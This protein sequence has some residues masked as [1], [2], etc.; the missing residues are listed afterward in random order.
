MKLVNDS[1][2]LFLGSRYNFIVGAT[3]IGVQ[4]AAENLKDDLI[5]LLQYLLIIQLYHLRLT[6]NLKYFGWI[7][8]ERMF[9]LHILITAGS[10]N[11][12]DQSAT[13]SQSYFKLSKTAE[14]PTLTLTL[15]TWSLIDTILQ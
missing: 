10:Q 2:Y 15:L 9:L 8:R 14:L 7:V 6:K 1:V 5:Y 4:T 11:Q 13:W 3:V 12:G